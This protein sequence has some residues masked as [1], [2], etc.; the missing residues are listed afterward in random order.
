M[1]FSAGQTITAAQLNRIQ[2]LPRVARATGNLTLTTSVQDVPGATITVSTSAAN[3]IYVVTG[4]FDCDV[5]SYS[6]D[7]AILG[8][9]YVDGAGVTG[10]A[11]W[12][13]RATAWRVTAAGTWSGTLASSGSHTLK[14][15][16]NKNVNAGTYTVLS[17]ST[18]LTL[19]VYEV[20]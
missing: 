16:A 9:L 8:G 12:L 4:V 3:A 11:V 15:V 18:A 13:G 17:G 1:A 14:L 2:P 7:P 20:V 5:T 19:H 10:S 6:G